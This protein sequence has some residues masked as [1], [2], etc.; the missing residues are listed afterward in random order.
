M[1]PPTT[2]WSTFSDSASST[3]SFVETFDPPTIATIGRAGLASALASASSSSVSRR[4]AA[5]VGANLA[6][7]WVDASARCAVPKASITKTSHRAAY[8]FAVSST[9]FFS[10][11]LTRQFSSTTSSPS[12][13]SKPPS[14]HSRIRRT[15]LPSFCAIT[16]TTGLSES[17]SLNSPS[18]GRPRWEVTITLAPALR[19]CSM[20]RIDAVMRASEVTLPSLTGT[21]MSARIKTRL[22][23]RSR[24]VTRMNAI[25]VSPEK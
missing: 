5:A 9:F 14:V 15:F 23:A 19:Q 17:S 1:P 2:S 11:L 21:F 24:S 3:V 7:P 22:P 25:A 12:A 16:S 18:V 20:V 4:P 6:M 10:P 13:T 8:F